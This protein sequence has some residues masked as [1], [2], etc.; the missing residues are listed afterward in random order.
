MSTKSDPNKATKQLKE[1][2]DALGEKKDELTRANN[3]EMRLRD[4]LS[5]KE[6]E[7]ERLK[8]ELIRVKAMAFDKLMDGK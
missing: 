1:L 7:C 2:M 6:K 4:A 3:M 5:A 8:D